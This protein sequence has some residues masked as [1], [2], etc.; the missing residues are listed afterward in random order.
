MDFTYFCQTLLKNDY[1][2]RS[3]EFKWAA[4]KNEVSVRLRTQTIKVSIQGCANYEFGLDIGESAASG[5]GIKYPLLWFL[6]T[7]AD[8][9]AFKAKLDLVSSLNKLSRGDIEVKELT[10]KDVQD[11]IVQYADNYSISTRQLT[12]SDTGPGLYMS[13]WKDGKS[14]PLQVT[15]KD[16]GEFTSMTFQ[17]GDNSEL[18]FVTFTKYK[19]VAK[20]ICY[21]NWAKDESYG[22][23][24][25]K[26]AATYGIP[27]LSST[28]YGIPE[29]RIETPKEKVPRPKVYNAQAA[30]KR[31]ADVRFASILESI[32]SNSEKGLFYL[33]L[34]SNGN[35]NNEIHQEIEK[36]LTELGFGI[37]LSQPN[38]HIVTW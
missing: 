3:S 22:Q 29:S 12:S 37:D 1:E 2:P 27:T 21:F 6:N 31:A 18:S 28:T 7:L 26:P 17:C 19:I 10:V 11:Y 38:R 35:V 33:D 30:R 36:R 16:V 32:K 13:I 9:L 15:Q 24:I 14:K 23:W 20:L 4:R 34:N 25:K 8:M 5:K